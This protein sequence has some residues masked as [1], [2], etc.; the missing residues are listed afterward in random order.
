[1]TLYHIHITK[2]KKKKEVAL[3]ATHTHYKNPGSTYP[4]LHTY[5]KFAGDFIAGQVLGAAEES[6]LHEDVHHVD[7]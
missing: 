2:R 3:T 7:G 4:A 5:M 1:M 6:G